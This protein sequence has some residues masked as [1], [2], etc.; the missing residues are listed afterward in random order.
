MNLI[1]KEKG[2]WYEVP[3][4]NPDDSKLYNGKSIP[5]TLFLSMLRSKP[6]HLGV[7]ISMCASCPL[8]FMPPDYADGSPL[9]ITYENPYSSICGM[10]AYADGLPLATIAQY[11][12]LTFAFSIFVVDLSRLDLRR[13]D[14]RAI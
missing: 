5:F 10:R 3:S 11:S 13:F 9:S 8:A 14:W 12:S 6:M 1:R 2:K 7:L 4:T